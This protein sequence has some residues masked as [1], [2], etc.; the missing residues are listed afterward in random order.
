MERERVIEL[1]IECHRALELRYQLVVAQL[2]SGDWIH[3]DAKYL[4]ELYDMS[5]PELY[6]ELKLANAAMMELY[7]YRASI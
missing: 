7:E 1:L 5:K 3:S 2:Q 4:N 6:T